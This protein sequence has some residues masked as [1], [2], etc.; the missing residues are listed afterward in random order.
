MKNTTLCVIFD[1]REHSHIA[2]VN[3]RL[4]HLTYTDQVNGKD[5]KGRVCSVFHSALD[6]DSNIY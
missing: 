2:L 1:S 5:V 3:V 6:L 4:S